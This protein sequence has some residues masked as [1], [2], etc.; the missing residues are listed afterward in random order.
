MLSLLGTN[1]VSLCV[2]A[3]IITVTELAPGA[4]PQEGAAEAIDEIIT[5]GTRRA[6]R[7]ASDSSVPI[8]VIGGDELV[9]IGYNDMDELLTR[10]EM[11]VFLVKTFGQ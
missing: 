3:A 10:A 5:T 1:R 2:L 7:S 9:N 4:R 11:K 6:E 8:D